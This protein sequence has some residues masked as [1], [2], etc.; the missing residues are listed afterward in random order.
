MVYRLFQEES[1][2]EVVA[3][4]VDDNFA[5]NSAASLNGKPIIR[6]QNV[7][8]NYEPHKYGFFLAVGYSNMRYRK[9]IFE[10]VKSLGYMMVNY[11]HPTAFIGNNV[12]LGQ[13]NIILYSS[14]IEPNVRMG[15][16]NIIWSSAVVSHDTRI[17]SHV[18]IA[19]QVMVGGFSFIGDNSF[20]GFNCTILDHMSVATETLIGAKSLLTKDTDPYGKY[21]GVPAKKVDEHM[22]HGIRIKTR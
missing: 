9:E 12:V 21:F 13:N 7:I 16:N 17:G 3:F 20:L 14:V 2:Y 5:L 18:F 15:D 10:K 19:S 6:L 11:I 22:E 1:L 4:C 8:Q